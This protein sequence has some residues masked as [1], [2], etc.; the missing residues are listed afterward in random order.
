[1]NLSICSFLPTGPAIFC[2]PQ[3]LYTKKRPL[4]VFVVCMATKK[5]Q[6]PLLPLLLKPEIDGFLI[7]FLLFDLFVP[8]IS[9]LIDIISPDFG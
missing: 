6:D 4:D 9:F 7:R 8:H 5:Q 1:M 2:F 3:I